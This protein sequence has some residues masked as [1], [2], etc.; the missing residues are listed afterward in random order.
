MPRLGTPGTQRVSSDPAYH[1]QSTVP[2]Y[3]APFCPSRVLHRVTD[4]L[5]VGSGIAGLRA[6]LEIP[7]HLDTIIVSKGGRDD[8]SSHWA[9]GGIAGVLGTDDRFEN[10]VADTVLAGGSLCDRDV[11]ERV[12]GEA[13]AR[14]GE[15]IDW[16]TDFDR[17][18]GE[19]ALGREA[20]HSHHRIVHALGDATGKEIMRAIVDQ[21]AAR[22]HLEVITAGFTLDLLVHEGRCVGAIVWHP[23][24]GMVMIWARETILCTGGA[25]QLYREST[26]PLVATGDGMALAYRAGVVLRDMEFMQ[27]HPT[28][29]YIAGSGRSLITE[30]VRG[31]GAHLVD[32]NGYRFMFDYDGRLEL[33]PRDVVSQAIVAQMEKTQHPCVY[34][35]LSHLEADHVRQRFPG[36][37][38]R[39]AKFGLDLHRDRI[40]VRP[41]AHYM[42][43]GVRCGSEG[44]TSLP[45][46]RAAG[47]VTSTGLHGANRL[48]SNS[49]LEGLVFGSNAGRAAAA[50]AERGPSA[51]AIMR[52][53][54]GVTRPAPDVPLDLAD[55]RNS[56]KSL[57]WRYVGVRRSG[58]GLVEAAR[59]IDQWCRYVLPCQFSQPE[60]WELQSMLT[61]AR[62]MV[63]SALAR[64]ESRGVH[65][66]TDFPEPDDLHWNRHYE[67]VRSPAPSEGP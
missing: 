48:A 3:L 61:V 23:D 11:V 15:L 4:L 56:L 32:R 22:H 57:M 6:A 2:R 5:I 9:Q 20:G 43:G 60:G 59:T 34:L 37:A 63:E 41:G 30:A 40:P 35:D 10:H 45:G 38:T 36:I 62:M 42:M 8:S 19:I 24:L 52:S 12:V 46:L 50:A 13:P 65:F 51:P 31:E 44:Q 16:G 21:V 53:L 67:V 33:A 25:G 58:D 27:F 47:E 29:L 28:V 17:E 54:V 14:I 49:L 64:R 1:F 7:S 39:C 66:R 26:N 55:I 18:Q